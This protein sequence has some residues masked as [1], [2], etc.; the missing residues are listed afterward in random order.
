VVDF[1][2]RLPAEE[3][4]RESASFQD[5]PKDRTSDAQLRIGEYRDSGFAP[6]HAP[7]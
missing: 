2:N 6:R 4:T 5:G 7:E 3:L 1:Q